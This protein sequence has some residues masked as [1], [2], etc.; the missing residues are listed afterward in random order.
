ML[1]QTIIGDT[2]E[3]IKII[4]NGKSI[5]RCIEIPDAYLDKDLEI[6][7]R[8]IPDKKNYRDHI[9]AIYLRYP[10][11]KPFDEIADPCQWQRE[12]RREW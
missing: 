6:T 8:P 7:I 1:N 9:K 11:S 12:I 5:Q 10:D 2:M 3:T 4:K